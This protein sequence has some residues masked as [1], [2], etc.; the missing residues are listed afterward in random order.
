[1]KIFS[2][3]ILI[4]GIS[5]LMFSSFACIF[6]GLLLGR[7]KIKGVSLGSAGVFILA[8]A[9]GAI[10]S[11]HIKSTVS[12]KTSAGEKV[13]ISSNALKIIEN[14]GLILFIGSV[15]FISGPNFFKNL[16][17]NFKSYLFVGLFVII[18]ASA[19]CIVIFFIAKKSGNEG[20]EFT[21]MLVG[22]Y[23]GALTST[24][25]FSAAKA[26][27]DEKYE[28]AVTVG[29]GIAYLFGVLGVVLFVQLSPKI[30]GANID[31]ERELL[32]DKKPKADQDLAK[33]EIKTTEGVQLKTE[34]NDEDKESNINSHRNLNK[35]SNKEN[36]ESKNLINNEDNDDKDNKNN[37]DNKLVILDGENEE[38]EKKDKNKLTDKKIESPEKKELFVLDKRGI[39][40]FGFS[41]LVGI[42]IGAIRIPLSNKGLD[43]AAFSLTTT[44]GVLIISLIIGHFGKICCLSLKIDKI[45]LENF[46]EL[47]L[48]LFLLGSGISGGTKFVEYFKA[49]YFLYGIIITILPLILGFIFNKYVLKLSLFNNLGSLTG[50]MTSTPA[51]GTLISVSKSELVGNPYAATY[52]ISL[53]TVVLFAQF[54]V[55]LLK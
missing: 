36:R 46:R 39:C 30:V 21:C 11:S 13:D 49:I 14:I 42:F 2:G 48:I 55:L 10:F 38:K 17:K 31:L 53:I 28:S 54:M 50:A 24:P 33:D 22:I 34:K 4:E 47:G 23:S 3:V 44:G 7:I 25:A 15:G 8:L 5:F 18:I 19:C 37:K 26:S 51:L 40:V 6:L 16:K 35:K 43:G 27:A 32:V 52:P 12:Q 1:M 9:Y 41:A 20:E 29:Y 45:V